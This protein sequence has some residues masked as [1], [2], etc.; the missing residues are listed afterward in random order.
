M[1]LVLDANLLHDDYLFENAQLR[2]ILAEQA[3][4]YSV[5]V[6]EV[7][8]RE[9]AKHYAAEKRSIA[10]IVRKLDGAPAMD[11]QPSLSAAKELIFARANKAG[12]KILPIPP[13]PH[14]DLLER[15]H[16]GKRPFAEDGH[17]GYADALVWESVKVAAKS[18]EVLLL[19]KDGD[20]GGDELDAKLA[21]EVQPLPHKVSKL[22]SYGEF[23]KRHIDPKRE[24]IKQ[25]RE[26]LNSGRA[27]QEAGALKAALRETLA[28]FDLP[29]DILP[30]DEYYTRGRVRASD[31]LTLS[32]IDVRPTGQ[33]QVHLRFEAIVQTEVAAEYWYRDHPDDEDSLAR[34]WD[35]YTVRLRV[36]AD[37]IAPAQLTSVT[38]ITVTSVD[39]DNSPKESRTPDPHGGF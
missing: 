11:A 4:G 1:L 16:E 31:V 10:R 29:R 21:A 39:V 6:S 7:A 30:D 18:E 14:G 28:D 3:F 35:F 23:I 27:A 5:A 36:S 9:H 33:N 15:A 26:D 25:L 37:A 8:L 32:A 20:F 19:S 2:V 34:D 13:V 12:L 24:V 22:R 38:S 17:V